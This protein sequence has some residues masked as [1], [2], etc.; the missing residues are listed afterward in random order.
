MINSPIPNMTG[1]PSADAMSGSL[2]F[3]KK[4]WSNMGVPGMVVPTLS[5]E[6]INKKITDLKAVEGWLS[7]NLNMLRTTIQALEVQNATLSALQAMG[8]MKV[9]D[10]VDGQTATKEGAEAFPWMTP[11]FSF[12]QPAEATKTPEPP[13][14]PAA[15]EQAEQASTK[16][17]HAEQQAAA[18]ANVWWD[19]L[20]SQFKQVV[21]SV[22]AADKTMATA[23]EAEDKPAVKSVKKPSKSA[24]RAA[25][26]AK[27][28]SPV[29]SAVKSGAAAS[30]TGARSSSTRN[31]KK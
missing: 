1:I 4:M 13:A 21:G 2:D 6:E 8:A 7:M 18:N 15:A 25:P 14:S 10:A 9:P 16:D 19:M 20:Q 3:I 23:A 24:S 28:K 17:A 31:V 30:K 22:V 5:V 26:V 12:G 29:K 11:S 27:R